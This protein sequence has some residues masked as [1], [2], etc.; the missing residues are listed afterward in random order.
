MMLILLVFKSNFSLKIPF[1]LSFFGLS[2]LNHLGDSNI[3]YSVSHLKLNFR[4]IFLCIQHFN[5]IYC[6]L[7]MYFKY[8]ISNIVLFQVTY[9]FILFYNRCKNFI[10]LNYISPFCPLCYFVLYFSFRNSVPVSQPWFSVKTQ[11]T[12][13][14][15][16]QV[17]WPSLF[18]QQAAISHTLENASVSREP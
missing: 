4:C 18:F 7:T 11:Y 13:K 2:L 15:F 12:L 9:Y 17:S 3:L 5:A 16:S 14:G 8:Y 10:I 1:I 6:I